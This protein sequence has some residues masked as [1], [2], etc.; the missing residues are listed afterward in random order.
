MNEETTLIRRSRL[1]QQYIVDAFSCIEEKRLTY[2]RRNQKDLKLKI[3]KGIKDTVVR[4][5]IDGNI[6]KKNYITINF[7]WR[8]KIHEPKLVI[9][10]Q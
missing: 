7:Y 9:K 3:Y 1:F 2:I 6:I 5:D 8:S 10:M 4:G